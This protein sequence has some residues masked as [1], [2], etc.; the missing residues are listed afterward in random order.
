[1]GLYL[2]RKLSFIST[3][4][5]VLNLD[6]WFVALSRKFI[7]FWYFINLLLYK[8]QTINNFLLFFWRNIFFFRYFF[9]IIIRNCFWII[10]W[11][12]SW[13]LCYIVSEFI[14]NQITNCLHCFLNCSFWSNFK[15]ICCRVFKMIKMFLAAFT[16]FKFLLISLPIFLTIFLAYHKNP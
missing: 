10:M 13:D 5:F 9:I 16:V 3:Q 1:M 14:T 2:P 4:Y 6:G 12:T 8:Y 11:W 15:C 7:I